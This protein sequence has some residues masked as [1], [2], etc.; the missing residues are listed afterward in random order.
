MTGSKDVA[1]G[2]FSSIGDNDPDNVFT[3]DAG[4]RASKAPLYFSD[5]TVDRNAHRAV[6]IN[7]RVRLRWGA[8]HDF[9]EFP[10]F[11]T[12]CGA[13]DG[14]IRASRGSSFSYRVPHLALALVHRGLFSNTGM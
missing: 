4:G 12:R 10:C 2:Q 14:N 3:L 1:P 5:E 7:F 8:G 9:S 11:D 6:L 13:G